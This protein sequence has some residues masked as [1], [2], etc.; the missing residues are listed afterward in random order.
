MLTADWVRLRLVAARV[1][2]AP[3]GDG[4]EGSQQLGVD[5]GAHRFIH[6]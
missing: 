1:K 3:I 4:D 6:H 5:V 2:P